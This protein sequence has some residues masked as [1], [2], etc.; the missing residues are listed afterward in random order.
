MTVPLITGTPTFASY[1]LCDAEQVRAFYANEYLTGE[2]VVGEP[3]P[4]RRFVVAADQL[5]LGPIEVTEHR[6]TV[7][8][9]A[10]LER[11]DVYVLC[12]PT[13]GTLVQEQQG[14]QVTGAP[15]RASM[16]RPAA[17]PAVIRTITG[18]RRSRTD[19]LVVKN[20]AVAAELELLLDRPVPSKIA[21]A[22]MVEF[23]GPE[24]H[25]WLRLLGLFT[26]ALR[27]RDPTILQP[28]VA[29]PLCHALLTGLLLISEHPYS[30]SVRKPAAT[31]RPR[32][33]KLT[34]DAMHEHPEQPHTSAS[35]AK[36]A[37]VSVRNLQEGFR[38]Y[39]GVPPMTYLRQLRLTRAHDDLHVGRVATVAEAAQKWGFAHLGRFAATYRA[40]Y[41][42]LPSADR[43]LPA[44]EPGEPS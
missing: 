35:L 42:A 15:R 25:S 22:P 30:D 1:R 2:G 24:S 44:A 6:L 11:D 14:I 40:K 12:L 28:I 39:V 27:R 38:R 33:V 29:E 17:G 26:D 3:A 4:G 32:H 18:G 13:S 19:G 31:C 37:G 5:F 21:F 7:D 36:L 10:G 9:T 23:T 8:V 41:G 34:L 43:G 16:Y 20:W